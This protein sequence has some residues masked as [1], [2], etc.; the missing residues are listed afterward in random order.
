MDV[1]SA[2][3]EVQVTPPYEMLGCDFVD[4]GRIEQIVRLGDSCKP[5]QLVGK[6]LRF[7][8]YYARVLS[9]KPEREWYK[10]G[11]IIRLVI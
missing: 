7:G 2:A 3:P 1:S 9:I 11:E 5:L 10:R 8:V 6:V 4:G